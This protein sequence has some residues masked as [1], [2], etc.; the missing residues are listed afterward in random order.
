[1][2]RGLRHNWVVKNVGCCHR[3]AATLC[4][5]AAALVAVGLLLGASGV[6]AKPLLLTPNGVANLQMGMTRSQ[7]ASVL[8]QSIAL[9]EDPDEQGCFYVQPTAY[10]ALSLM[11]VSDRLSRIDAR[12]ADVHTAEGVG[13]GDAVA[14]VKT[15]YGAQL[16]A[17]PHFYEAT[18]EHYLTLQ[19][20]DAD[21]AIRF[22]TH[23]GVI[24]AL[25]AGYVAQ[26]HYVEGCL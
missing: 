22:E 13:I 19:G 2:E 23:D 20:A 16:I 8:G 24:A 25:Y 15:L 1:M 18:S 6:Q 4:R 3:I 21:V 5:Q 11:F 14:K 7:V 9:P 26:V 17:E 12:S 10:P